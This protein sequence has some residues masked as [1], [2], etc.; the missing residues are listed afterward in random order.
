MVRRRRGVMI[1]R[2]TDE[3][4]VTKTT[5]KIMIGEDEGGDGRGCCCSMM[6]F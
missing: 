3:S 6:G 4:K 1:M 2:S 5:M